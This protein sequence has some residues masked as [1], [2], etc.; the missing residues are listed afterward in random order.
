MEQ[1][2]VL[3]N[4]I[5]HSLELHDSEE[6][7][8][9]ELSE[10]SELIQN[11][12]N[13]PNFLQILSNS[14]KVWNFINQILK[15]EIKTNIEVRI[16]RG[17]IILSRNLITNNQSL[18]EDLNV[19]LIQVLESL[20]N[21]DDI[22]PNIINNLI[23]S[24]F[25]Y[26]GNFTQIKVKF[27][28]TLFIGLNQFISHKDID[29]SNYEILFNILFNF[30]KDDDILYQCLS[31]GE[32]KPI[33]SLLNQEFHNLDLKSKSFSS[34]D[35]LIFK[36]FK[37]LIIHESYLKFITKYNETIE[38]IQYLRISQALI[39]S[40]SEWDIL[41]LTTILSWTFEY[42]DM[43][44]NE[45]E[46][47]FKIHD[48]EGNHVSNIYQKLHIILDIYTSLIIFDH[49]KK[50]LESYKG[51]EL[52]IKL[53][54]ILHQNIPQLKLK[55]SE[56]SKFQEEGIP[57]SHFPGCKS[58]I[59][60]ILSSLT[61]MNSTI[62]DKIR[63][64]HGLEV[65]LSNCNI[66]DNEPFIKERAIVCLRFLLLN[67]QENQKFVAQLEA[68]Q[69]VKDETIDEMGYDVDIVDGKVQLKK[70]KEEV[71]KVIG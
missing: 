50:F 19:T 52:F 35:L 69:V 53:L 30:T 64:L 29:Q 70:K 16:I 39:T 63:E 26:L 58:L 25:E 10:L 59:I 36:I 43:V 47:Y 48:E 56:K 13:N 37:K 65:I 3:L 22:S 68:R 60:E 42:L 6:I 20:C 31:K 61:Y 66:D 24:S 71:Q 51:V 2:L 33:L 49:S 28:K 15:T 46:Q 45:L 21:R 14:S 7:F 62:Q 11:T 55:D 17:I 23:H 8:L 34:Y 54:G 44:Y 27:D 38:T 12:I 9:I 18:I 67:N 5:N 57:D 4:S 40:T 32:G 41:D 1:S